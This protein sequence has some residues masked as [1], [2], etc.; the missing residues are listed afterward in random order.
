M[1]TCY[2]LSLKVNDYTLFKGLSFTSFG[3]GT[4]LIKGKNG[5]GKSSL[6]RMIAGIQQHSGKIIFKGNLIQEL[7]KPYCV[8]IG[9]KT[10][11]RLDLSVIQNLVF[12]AKMYDSD[13]MLEAAIRYWDLYDVL[14]TECHKLSSGTQKKVALA[15]LLCCNSSLWLLDEVDTNLD[16]ENFN[17]LQNLLHIKMDSGGVIICASHNN[18]LI[19]NSELNTLYIE[20][21]NS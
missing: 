8:Y 6:L 14:E 4:L 13:L 18:N 1:L 19:Q 5:S 2:N 16:S 17:L 3:G 15:K 11:I 9:H 20:D 21:F 12:W 10:G 7:N